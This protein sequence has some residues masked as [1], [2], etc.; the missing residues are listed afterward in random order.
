MRRVETRN[1]IHVHVGD[2]ICLPVIC[3]IQPEHVP[4]FQRAG[5]QP[6]L[7]DVADNIQTLMAGPHTAASTA[8]AV[9]AASKRAQ[10]HA[11]PVLR[12]GM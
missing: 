2:S 1:I 3:H 5:F 11:L 7:A 6:L 8:D 9:D 10:A 4:H 12:D